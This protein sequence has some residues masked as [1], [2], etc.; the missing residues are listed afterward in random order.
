MLANVGK[1][2]QKTR[3]TSVATARKMMD[4]LLRD[5][6]TT[7]SGRLEGGFGIN[8]NEQSDF[9][10]AIFNVAA[11]RKILTNRTIPVI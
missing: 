1:C 6:L 5:T 7:S 4:A 10:S 11:P 2:L 8:L 9:F 3:I